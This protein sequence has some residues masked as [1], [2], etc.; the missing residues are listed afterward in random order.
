MNDPEQVQ[1]YVET[2]FSASDQALA[3]RIRASITFTPKRILDLGCGPGNITFLMAAAYPDATVV[4][5]DGAENMIDQARHLHR[6]E[7]QHLQNLSFQ[8][9]NLPSDAIYGDQFDLI[10]SNS[11]LHHLHDPFVLWQEINKAISLNGFFYIADLARPDTYEQAK[12]LKDTYVS[13]APL[14]LQHD[15][16]Q[17][18]L[19]AYSTEEIKRQLQEAGFSNFM[20]EM[21]TDRHVHCY[22]MKNEEL[23]MKN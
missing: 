19:A 2:D 14:I 8:V 20:V 21:V 4:G 3:K 15:F 12:Y 16:Y 13:E 22:G 23:R 6:K 11:L 9:V 7:Y 17:S 5:I 1:A 10:I 18:L